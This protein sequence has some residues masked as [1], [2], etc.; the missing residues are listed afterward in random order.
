MFR[1][2]SSTLVGVVSRIS[3]RTVKYHDPEIC[4]FEDDPAALAYCRLGQ[5]EGGRPLISGWISEMFGKGGP[6]PLAG[7]CLAARHDSLVEQPLH[8]RWV[9]IWHLNPVGRSA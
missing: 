5:S 7:F 6:V 2:I 8:G 4:L 9:R 3:H 1:R